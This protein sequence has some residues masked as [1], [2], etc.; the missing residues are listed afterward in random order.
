MNKRNKRR[1]EWWWEVEEENKIWNKWGTHDDTVPWAENY[2]S[3]GSW[4]PGPPF[5]PK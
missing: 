5:P 4:H 3:L 2:E 1:K